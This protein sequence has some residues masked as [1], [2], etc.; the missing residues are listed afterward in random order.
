[1]RILRH[2]GLMTAILMFAV[3]AHA[4]AAHADSLKEATAA[5]AKKQY[6]AAIKL[7]RPLAEKGNAIAQYKV[8]VMHRM[9]L[10]VPKSEKEARK[11]S[12]LAAKQGNP[13][14]QT[15]LGSLYYKASG[16]ESPD[17]VRAYMW[18]EVAAAQGNAEAKKDLALLTKELTPQQVT[19]AR[20]KAQ[21][22]KSSGYEQCD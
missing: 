22:C 21:K 5:F 15:L 3:T 2:L 8:A 10:G 19:E 7:F 6:A 17:T 16:E 20:E 14:A 4:P 12:R 18:Y 13:Q 9:G 1:M 11:W